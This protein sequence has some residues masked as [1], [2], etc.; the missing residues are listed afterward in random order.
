[1]VNREMPMEQ[2]PDAF[3]CIVKKQYTEVFI[4]FGIEKTKKGFESTSAV[5]QGD[6]L[7]PVLFIIVMQAVFD[8]LNKFWTISLATFQMSTAYSLIKL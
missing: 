8:S 1:M 6:S 7:A 2:P 3:I 5:K 4:E